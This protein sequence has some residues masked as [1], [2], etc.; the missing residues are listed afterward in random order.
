MTAV[1]AFRASHGKFHP[2]MNASRLRPRRSVCA[3]VGVLRR[4]P[5]HVV[6]S[7]SRDTLLVISGE[8]L[9]GKVISKAVPPSS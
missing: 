4:R 8:K 5:R 3:R 2:A 9:I 6:D 1:A 7:V